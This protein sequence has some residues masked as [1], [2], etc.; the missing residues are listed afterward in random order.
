VDAEAERL[1]GAG[2]IRLRAFEQH[3]EYWVVLQNPEGH[4]FCFQ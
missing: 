3:G 4:E 1:V 2:T